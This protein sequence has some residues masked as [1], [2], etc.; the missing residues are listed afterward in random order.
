M[1][2]KLKREENVLKRILIQ[3]VKNNLREY[4]ILTI[5]FFIG[6]MIGVILVNNVNKNQKE[7]LQ[8]YIRTDL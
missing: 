1:R 5:L 3:H 8:S 4:I 6:I 7:D 2:G